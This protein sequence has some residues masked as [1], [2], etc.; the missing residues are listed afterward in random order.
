MTLNNN[1]AEIISCTIQFNLHIKRGLPPPFK[2][3]KICNR[4]MCSREKIN[5]IS[6]FNIQILHRECA[7]KDPDASFA[8]LLFHSNIT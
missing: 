3:Y 4:I 8:N 2:I 7:A 6:S 1:N 5:K